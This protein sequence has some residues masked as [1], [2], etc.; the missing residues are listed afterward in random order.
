MV[1]TFLKGA[2]GIA[3]RP[4]RRIPN[5]WTLHAL[6]RRLRRLDALGRKFFFAPTTTSGSAKTC[7]ALFRRR[8]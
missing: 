2:R 1:D 5:H 7:E 4:V 8:L 6:R 3:R